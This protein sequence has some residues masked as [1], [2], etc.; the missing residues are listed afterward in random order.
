MKNTLTLFLILLVLAPLGRAEVSFQ[1]TVDKQSAAFEDR[2]ELTLEVRV[3][4]PEIHT[5]P[6]PPPQISGMT[7]GGSTS[8]V[9]RQG[10]TIIRSYTYMLVPRRSGAITIPPFQLE[11]TDSLATDTLI[12]EPI[13]VTI[14]Q[15]APQSE[16]SATPLWLLLLALAIILVGAGWWYRRTTKVEK[17]VLEDW[18]G[19]FRDRLKEV[20]K[21]ADREDYRQFSVEAMKLIVDLLER[22]SDRRLTG[23]TAKDLVEL[24]AAEGLPDSELERIEQQFTFLESVKYSAGAVNTEDGRRAVQRLRKIV[25]LLL[26]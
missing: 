15:P 19:P 3:D 6:L 18:R 8:T 1:A 14:A 2:I 17:P 10:D 7:L 23:Q 5:S 26:M 16:E 12:S 9:D 24:L 13:T 22:R 4:H 25:E 20:T 11:F 21:Y